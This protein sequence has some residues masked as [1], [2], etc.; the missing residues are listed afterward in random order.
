MCKLTQAHAY[1]QLVEAKLK[2]AYQEGQAARAVGQDPLAAEL[3]AS[4]HRL[5]M[6]AAALIPTAPLLVQVQYMQFLQ[7]YIGFRV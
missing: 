4:A 3:A 6:Q 7:C 2:R 5:R 1:L